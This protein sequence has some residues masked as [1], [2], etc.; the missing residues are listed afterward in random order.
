MHPVDGPEM[1]FTERLLRAF[2]MMDFLAYLAKSELSYTFL[3]MVRSPTSTHWC[4]LTNIYLPSPHSS[5][6]TCP[7][8]RAP[9]VQPS[10]GNFLLPDNRPIGPNPPWGPRR[11]L[12][13]IHL[14]SGLTKT[15]VRS[16]YHLAPPSQGSK[17][18]VCDRVKR[19]PHGVLRV[20]ERMVHKFFR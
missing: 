7:S 5:V 17:E 12:A 14:R 10:S 1:R 3:A 2:A 6:F 20:S 11:K 15:R 19:L 9:T 4:Q 18:R 8:R 16:S 13:W